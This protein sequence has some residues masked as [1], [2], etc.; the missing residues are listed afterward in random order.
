M[1]TWQQFHQLPANS[2]RS[3]V[4][5]PEQLSRCQGRTT[6]GGQSQRGQQKSGSDLIKAG[7]RQHQHRHRRRHRHRTT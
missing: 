2:D 4:R 3:Q 6:T 5:R 7:Q 1:V